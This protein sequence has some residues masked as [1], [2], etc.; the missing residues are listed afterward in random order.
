MMQN[1]RYLIGYGTFV[2]V[3]PTCGFSVFPEWDSTP[4]PCQNVLH[5]DTLQFVAWVLS[6]CYVVVVLLY[7]CVL[8]FITYKL[9]SIIL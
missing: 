5:G 4:R 1:C 6:E 2:N 8:Q 9:S 7:R 3:A